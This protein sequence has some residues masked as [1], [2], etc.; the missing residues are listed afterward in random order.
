MFLL[1]IKP[2][3][4]P[5]C[6]Q[7]VAAPSCWP[8]LPQVM[9]KRE[10]RERREEETRSVGLGQITGGRRTH[11]RPREMP[12]PPIARCFAQPFSPKLALLT[13]NSSRSVPNGARS[14]SLASERAARGWY[15]AGSGLGR[16]L[17]AASELRHHGFAVARTGFGPLQTRVWLGWSAPGLVRVRQEG[18]ELGRPWKEHWLL[19]EL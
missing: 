16:R 7:C 2:N 1:I 3:Y 19:N 13:S 15:R 9:G 5:G 8:A 12:P 10:K 11:A 4:D 6:E 14:S 18:R 17:P